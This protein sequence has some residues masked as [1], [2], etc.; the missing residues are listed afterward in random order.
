M[1]NKFLI[2][3]T[4]LSVL[5]CSSLAPLEESNK[6]YSMDDVSSVGFKVKK[7][8]YTEFTREEFNRICMPIINRI[9]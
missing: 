4:I 3:L 1:R 9:I 6:I 2:C 7:D 8:F 5:S